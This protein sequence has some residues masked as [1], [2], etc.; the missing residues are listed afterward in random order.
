MSVT[1]GE[2]VVRA[3]GSAGEG[4]KGLIESREGLV[5]AEGFRPAPKIS[6]GAG[7][8]QSAAPSAGRHHVGPMM[9][10]LVRVKFWCFPRA[11][12]LASH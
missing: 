4:Q 7:N 12:Q 9:A 1:G 11:S 10:M 3:M 5:C 8:G 2:V 6:E